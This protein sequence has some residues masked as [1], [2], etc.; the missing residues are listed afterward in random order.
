VD[1]S[2]ARTTEYL[3]AEH[4]YVPNWGPREWSIHAFPI[5]K[6]TAKRIYY[7]RK[8]LE[9]LPEI[10]APDVSKQRWDGCPDDEIGFADRQELEQTGETKKH[11]RSW[12]SVLSA[13]I[14]A[15]GVQA[16]R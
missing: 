13:A 5:V 16:A 12:E 11:G 7:K 9:W 10:E 6:K 4:C 8:W 1:T 14:G 3:F 2:E 15:R